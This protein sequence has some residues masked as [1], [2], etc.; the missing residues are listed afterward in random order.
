MGQ[1]WFFDLM[2]NSVNQEAIF[3]L[4]YVI[5][6]H[7]QFKY[8]IVLCLGMNVVLILYLYPFQ[9]GDYDAEEKVIRLQSEL[10]GNASKVIYA[11]YW[12]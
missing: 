3:S 5:W 10:V 8:I 1:S 4:I 12:L 2:Q 6:N 11:D 7:R 9:K